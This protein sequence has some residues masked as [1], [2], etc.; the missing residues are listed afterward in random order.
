M[1]Q[2]RYDTLFAEWR[3][4]TCILSSTS[5]IAK[6]PA[7]REIVAAGAA[8][9]PFLLAELAYGN[10]GGAWGVFAALSEITND[11]PGG[12]EPGVVGQVREAW[13]RWGR[14]RGYLG[15]G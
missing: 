2:E 13:L 1:D 14:G 11:D 6:H 5:A 7:C 12:Y 15:G 9:L 8:S 10:R 4:D 3:R